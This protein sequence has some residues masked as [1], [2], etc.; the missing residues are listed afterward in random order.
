MFRLTV[1]GQGEEGVW[2]EFVATSWARG[3]WGNR[4]PRLSSQAPSPAW[5]EGSEWSGRHPRV[6]SR[7]SPPARQTETTASAWWCASAHL[8]GAI[9][10]TVN[11]STRGWGKKSEQQGLKGQFTHITKKCIFSYLKFKPGDLQFLIFIKFHEKTKTNNELI[12]KKKT[13]KNTTL[14]WVTC[15]LITMNTATICLFW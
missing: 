2:S 8:Q 1:G 6:T 4:Q 14:H 15:S 5:A 11:H 9:R 10:S 7:T 12:A 13:T 3:G